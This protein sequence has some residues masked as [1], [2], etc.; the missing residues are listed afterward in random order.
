MHRIKSLT[1]W[2]WAVA[3]NSHVIIAYWK[4]PGVRKLRMDASPK[5]NGNNDVN[6]AIILPLV[7][8]LLRS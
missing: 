3:A 1:A 4:M 6:P 8:K 5:T 7:G 2:P